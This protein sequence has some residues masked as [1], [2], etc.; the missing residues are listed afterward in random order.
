[1]T[2]PGTGRTPA[3]LGNGDVDQRTGLV[4]YLV[5]LGGGVTAER[6][7]WAGLVHRG[8]QPRCP[9]RRGRGHQVDAPAERAPVTRADPPADGIGRHPAVESLLTRHD[10]GLCL[11]NSSEAW[12]ESWHADSL[13]RP[14]CGPG[15]CSESLWTAVCGYPVT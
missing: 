3:A 4:S 10:A 2:I 12:Q 5:Q 13:T 8:P 7:S 1:M 6:R 14:I 11:G 15:G 9:G